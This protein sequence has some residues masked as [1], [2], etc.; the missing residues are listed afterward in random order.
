MR[1][2]AWPAGMLMNQDRCI[3]PDFKDEAADASAPIQLDP[4]IQESIGKALQAHYDDVAR[5]P[6]PDSI[7]ALLAELA[8]KGRADE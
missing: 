1:L 8:A 5:M 3:A 2:P 7:L 4:R 6:L